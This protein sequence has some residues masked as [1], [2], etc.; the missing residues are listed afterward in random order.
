MPNHSFKTRCSTLIR[1][2]NNEPPSKT[3][4]LIATVFGDIV[5]AHGG[6][7]W[8][9][10]LTRLLAPLGVSERLVRTAV[11]RLSQDGSLES[12]KTGRRSY[13]RLT[14]SARLRVDRFDRRIYYFGEPEW[15][16]DWR[17]VFA[18]TK[19]ISAA[20]R[21]EVRRRMTWLGFGI[22][23]PNVYG[24]PTAPVA[25]VWQLMETLGIAGKVTIMRAR[26]DDQTVGL[27]TGD[28]VRQCFDIDRLEKEY[29]AFIRRYQPL[30]QALQDGSDSNDRN[31]E[32]CLVIRIMLIHQYRRIL[33]HDPELPTALLPP[34]WK[35][36]AAHRLC[37]L[38]YK[39]VEQGANAQIHAVAEDRNGAFPAVVA[40]HRQR[41]A[42]SGIARSGTSEITG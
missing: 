26:N 34:D 12:I 14:A 29:A 13:Y 3:P 17:L 41:F 9:G 25:P 38:I 42:A 20:Q 16:G 7:I 22:I 5:E 40:Q 24:H 28:M 8:L 33:L 21:A 31:P 18:G 39:A 10:S 2:L 6:E 11:Y 37:A 4:S 36:S 27:G 23:A 19:G 1:D 30:A 32:H 35:G 15:D